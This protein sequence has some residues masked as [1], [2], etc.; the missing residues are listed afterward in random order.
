MLCLVSWRLPTL[1][2][3]GEDKKSSFS[4]ALDWRDTCAA[5][6]ATVPAKWLFIRCILDYCK[7]L[8]WTE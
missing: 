2:M 1:F 3:L 5:L 4:V 7:N 6:A 8:V